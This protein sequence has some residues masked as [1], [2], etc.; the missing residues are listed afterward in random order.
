MNEVIENCE[1]AEDVTVKISMDIVAV[2]SLQNGKCSPLVDF[3]RAF[4]LLS[5]ETHHSVFVG[6]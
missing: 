2:G 3:D 6:P 4:E 1:F 5:R